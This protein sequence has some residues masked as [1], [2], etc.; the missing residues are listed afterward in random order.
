M[1][2]NHDILSFEDLNSFIPVSS[3]SCAR[4]AVE[5]EEFPPVISRY[6]ISF[7][8]NHDP[9]LLISKNYFVPLLTLLVCLFLRHRGCAR[10]QKKFRRSREHHER[11]VE[12]D[13]V[14]NQAFTNL[15]PPST[16]PPPLGALPLLPPAPA[17]RAPPAPQLRPEKKS[18]DHCTG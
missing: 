15:P 5:W 2:I 16:P 10:R 12:L 3:T 4:P 14:H 1:Q 6:A 13:I 9:Y 18:K 17:A 8:L 7:L 11:F